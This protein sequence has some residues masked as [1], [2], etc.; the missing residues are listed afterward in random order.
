MRLRKAGIII[1]L[2]ICLSTLDSFSTI[3]AQ[4][5]SASITHDGEIILS[6]IDSLEINSSNYTQNG[7]IIIRDNAILRITDSVLNLS[8]GSSI[9]LLGNGQLIID[10]SKLNLAGDHAE[11]NA[12]DR[13][14]VRLLDSDVIRE[15]W[16]TVHQ[17]Y[18]YLTSINMH[19]D[20]RLDAENSRMGALMASDRSLSRADNSFIGTLTIDQKTN[21][22]VQVS[23]SSID[24]LTPQSGTCIVE[25]STVHHMLFYL[26]NSTYTCRLSLDNDLESWNTK[27][28]EGGIPCDLTLQNT[29]LGEY[30]VYAFDSS[31]EIRDSNPDSILL[32][33]GSN[34]S[35]THC[36]TNVRLDGDT[37]ET[38]EIIDSH[39]GEFYCDP[40]ATLGKL[41][42]EGSD[43]RLAELNLGEY[44]R[45]EDARVG[46]WW[47]AAYYG[48][49]GSTRL[50]DVSDSNFGNFTINLKTAY[51]FSNVTI[52][53][54]AWIMYSFLNEPSYIHGPSYIRGDVTFQNRNQVFEF[55]LLTDTQY[56]VT[57]EYDVSVIRGGSPLSSASMELQSGNRTIW[58][59]ESDDDGRARFNVT[60]TGTYVLN[61][62]PGQP[63]L[64]NEEN[65]TQ[66]LNLL[67]K[68]RGDITT[69][70]ISLLCETPVEIGFRSVYPSYQRQW[71]AILFLLLLVLV[72]VSVLIRHTQ[73]RLKPH[74]NE[75]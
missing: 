64:V 59:G 61:Q 50:V 13:S 31:L 46:R 55:D 32:S 53:D 33:G 24:I 71:F 51:T 8:N 49:E 56:M 34:I 66:T 40:V 15:F 65:M 62:I 67:V 52:R 11:I 54:R 28:D 74:L 18:H 43:I 37:T 3:L 19:N 6:S 42:I 73:M 25:K 41:H 16:C 69:T 10:H 60:Y 9:E 4:P 5:N 58:R 17:A 30:R 75:L 70:S 1:I 35:I 29:N 14:K 47:S 44:T 63:P 26:M 2:A 7:N 38:I 57:R 48:W 21:A 45:I 12:L 20:T 36:T 27:K 23:N 72:T 22:F 68:D 39:I